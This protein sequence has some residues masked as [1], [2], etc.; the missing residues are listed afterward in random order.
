MRLMSHGKRLMSMMGFFGFYY[1]CYSVTFGSFSGCLHRSHFFPAILA[2]RSPP[3]ACKTCQQRPQQ[4][5]Y[6]KCRLFQGPLWLNRVHLAA[7]GAAEE[8][9]DVK[10]KTSSPRSLQRLFKQALKF[11]DQGHNDQALLVYQTITQS[12]PE[13]PEAWLNLGICHAAEGSDENLQL[14]LQGFD[15]ALHLDDTYHDAHYNKALVLDDL[16]LTS[17]A[18]NMSKESARFGSLSKMAHLVTE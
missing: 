2:C 16:G 14:A 13:C 17:E 10:S 15:Q 3:A 18:G 1:C 9:K 11:S 5:Q 4:A 6:S 12:Y 8:Q 7:S